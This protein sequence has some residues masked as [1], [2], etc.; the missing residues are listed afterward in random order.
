MDIEPQEHDVAN[1]W[2]V[3]FLEL[4]DIVFAD[5]N[6]PADDAAFERL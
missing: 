2:P 1:G 6:S 3:D 4:A 5:W